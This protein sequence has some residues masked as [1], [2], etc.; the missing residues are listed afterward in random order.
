MSEFS[1][2][3]VSTSTS[4][5]KFWEVEVV[6]SDMRVRYGKLGADSK[7]STKS[8]ET[9]EKALKEADK[10]FRSKI[11]KGYAEAPRPTSV[12]ADG[13][14][15][16]DSA[17][18]GVFYFRAFNRSPGGNRDNFTIK[19]TV[20]K[21]AGEP[22]T[23]TGKVYRDWDGEHFVYPEAKIEIPG[24]EESVGVMLE[25]AQA[26][27]ENGLNESEFTI[28]DDRLDTDAYDTEWSSLE[29]SLH[30]PEGDESPGTLVTHVVQ[31]GLSFTNSKG[32]PPDETS[33]RFIDAV[34]S[35]AGIGRVE[36]FSENKSPFSE[37]YNPKV[38][39]ESKGYQGGEVPLYL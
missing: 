36:S 14:T 23:L 13:V 22:S 26:L 24:Q 3:I 21:P 35:L 2:Y 10:K 33:Q 32:D 30:V 20:E 17:I 38:E 19:V 28:I 37:V 8:F 15:L 1:K 4:G 25:A 6:G 27:I 18:N 5:G 7:W 39:G 31:K 16:A 9:P 29:F 11:R 12:D 34:H